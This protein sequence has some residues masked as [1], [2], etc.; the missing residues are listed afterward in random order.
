MEEMSV[1]ARE[2]HS[3]SPERSTNQVKQVETPV[4]VR[5]GQPAASVFRCF[6]AH[7]HRI[8]VFFRLNVT[9]P[10]AEPAYLF[11]WNGCKCLCILS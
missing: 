2:M 11:R 9:S 3:C 8:M 5:R 7:V 4:W 1:G 6:S 10:Q